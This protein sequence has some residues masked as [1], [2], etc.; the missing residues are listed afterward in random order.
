M[1]TCGT[2]IMG[3]LMGAPTPLDLPAQ[4]PAP[5][6]ELDVREALDGVTDSVESEHFAFKWGADWDPTEA[7]LELVLDSLE[8]AWEDQFEGLG[9]ETPPGTSI[10]KLNVYQSG[11]GVLQNGVELPDVGGAYTST[12]PEGWPLIVLS[13]SSWQIDDVLAAHGFTEPDEVIAFTLAHELQHASQMASS[14]YAGAAD[15]WF[16]ETRSEWAARNLY[17]GS[18]L[19]SSDGLILALSPQLAFEWFDFAYYSGRTWDPSEPPPDTTL[20]FYATWILTQ[21]LSETH[22]EDFVVRWSEED[23]DADT[24]LDGLA[25][26]LGDD[27][28]VHEAIASAWGRARTNDFREEAWLEEMFHLALDEQVLEDLPGFEPLTGQLGLDEALTPPPE[29]HR[30]Q[31]YGANRWHLDAPPTELSVVFEGDGQGSEGTPTEWKIVAVFDG[32]DG[33]DAW[34]LVEPSAEGSLLEVPDDIDTLE[35]YVVAGGETY[36]EEEQFDYALAVQ[37]PVVVAD[38]EDVGGCCSS[39]PGRRQ[40]WLLV[41]LVGL[42]AA[43]RLRRA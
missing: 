37:T 32:E 30:P 9:F 3:S 5:D 14:T 17:P 10:Y 40:P 27:D 43:P 42:L 24:P 28:A 2:L 39:A 15:T 33:D 1:G 11:S 22:G 13:E 31:R 12:D 38:G 25:V 8:A 6:G 7:Q 34:T 41:V 35:L 19:A 16:L 4:A 36:V 26:L 18:Y 23:L 20:H 21:H 29:N